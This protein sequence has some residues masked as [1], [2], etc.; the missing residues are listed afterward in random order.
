MTTG[1]QP[2]LCLFFERAADLLAASGFESPREEARA[3]VEAVAGIPLAQQLARPRMVLDEKTLASLER[4]LALRLCHVPLGQIA[5]TVWFCGLPFRV[6]GSTLIPRP[7][8]EHLVEAA[9]EF[10]CDFVPTRL[11]IRILDTFTGTGAV[12]ISLG[13]QLKEEGLAFDLTLAD[14]SGEALEIAA[15]NAGVILPDQ[16]PVLVRTDIWPQGKEAFDLI[17]ANPPYIP[18]EE[19][20]SLMPEVARFEPVT[21]LDGGPDGLVLYRRLAAEGRERL[22]AEGLLILEAGA[23][24][25]GLIASVFDERGWQEEG[26][27]RDYLG[28]ERVL[29][30]SV[31]PHV[32]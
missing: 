12:G 7:E 1:R 3:L 24:Q 21:A 2:T 20:A 30:F 5:G 4:A 18:T 9:M 17:L 23:G 8:T 11:P 32:K 19:I 6:T 22:S 14:I 10:C 15:L 29:M 26:R 16:D 25:A 28:H 31:R 27:V 13:F